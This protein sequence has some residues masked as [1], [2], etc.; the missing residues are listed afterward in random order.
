MI[1]NQTIGVVIPCY[2]GGSITKEI[3]CESLQNA[4][5]VVLVDDACPQG[6]GRKILMEV[7]SS[8]LEVL[9]NLKNRGVGYSTKKGINFLLEKKCD[10]ILKLDADGQLDPKEIFC[11]CQPIIQEKY[12]AS[13]GNR[14]GNVENALKMPKIRLLGILL[15]SFITK[16]STGYWDLFDP[17]NGFLCFKKDVLENINLNK[18][19]DRYFFETDLLF[20]CSLSNVKIKNVNISV[21]YKSNLS[22]LNPIQQ[23]PVFFVK[24]IERIIKRIV[25]QY[26]I[27]D[28]NPGSIE[29]LLSFFTGMVGL[30]IG[31]TSKYRGF[32][33]GIPATPGTASLFTIACILTI[34]LLL[35]FVYYDCTYRVFL[36]NSK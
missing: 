4:D 15:L 17:T 8:R 30:T 28:F 19:D 6:T 24:H 32:I 36:R 35:S 13:K 16:I 2:K 34:Q 5:F 29:L 22:S 7:K 18:I 25:Y 11:M 14:F 20:R 10:L 33:S 12:E 9:F 26:F 31:I 27:F 1:L 21:N 3:V 23:I